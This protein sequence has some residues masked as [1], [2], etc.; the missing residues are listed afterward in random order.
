MAYTVTY[1]YDLSEGFEGFADGHLWSYEPGDGYYLTDLSVINQSQSAVSGN[2]YLLNVYNT[3]TSIIVDLKIVDDKVFEGS[4]KFAFDVNYIIRHVG[5]PD[6]ELADLIGFDVNI[7]DGHCFTGST[8]E[9]AA[10]AV[11]TLRQVA[12]DFSGV[13]KQIA[14]YQAVLADKLSELR[15]WENDAE[16]NIINNA[17]NATLAAAAVVAVVAG[18]ATTVGAVATLVAVGG[19]ITWG[20]YT[21]AT[22]LAEYDG[23]AR[24]N[25]DIV[26][27]N[28]NRMATITNAIEE[29]ATAVSKSI[30]N[31]TAVISTGFGVYKAGELYVKMQE[32]HSAIDTLRGQ[33]SELEATASQTESLIENIRTELF[34]QTDCVETLTASPLAS[35]PL[36][37]LQELAGAALEL[38]EGVEHLEPLPGI[39]LTSNF[40]DDNLTL[41]AATYQFFLGIVPE[42]EGFEYLIE[43]P[44]NS[45]DLSDLYYAQFNQENRFI[46]FSNNLGSFGAGADDFSSKYGSLTFEQTVRSA[47]EEII[48]TDAILA[49]G[50][51]PEATVQF[52]LGAH[53]FYTAVANERVVPGGVD[54]D[55]A[56][57]VVAIGSVLHEATKAGVGRYAT[58]IESLIA[59]IREDG[60]S[61]YFGED[62]FSMGF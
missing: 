62:I 51:D 5:D 34:N 37:S 14:A 33:I 23:S 9:R 55:Q 29:T 35:S 48:G 16:A 47:V 25:V 8:A 31:I 46:N 53:W 36:P 20:A 24:G 50:G 1:T 44:A 41:V 59:D 61:A 32:L 6:Y 26:N 19:G 43:S 10:Q 7:R 27:T 39:T 4:E 57:K 12:S 30:G 11:N 3:G 52:F 54:V 2:D 60:R 21:F 56:V 13:Q 15:Q 17:V 40:T 45:A 22:Q 18:T 58:Q 28:M 49:R 38:K 42:A